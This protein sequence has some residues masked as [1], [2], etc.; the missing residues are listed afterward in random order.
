MKKI[1]LLLV[2]FVMSTVS[3]TIVA[4]DIDSRFDAVSNGAI[5]DVNSSCN[6]VLE[7]FYKFICS[8]RD[9]EEFRAERI[10]LNV[11]ELEGYVSKDNAEDV[12]EGS[13]EF[14]E[15]AWYLDIED[16]MPSYTS[17]SASWFDVSG[18]KACYARGEACEDG[19][20]E[21]EVI[22]IFE[23]IDGK[24]F[25][26]SYLELATDEDDSEDS[27]EEEDVDEEEEDETEEDEEDE[28][29]PVAQ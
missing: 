19:S 2:L 12:S 23:C 27:Y 1:G 14:Y 26:T 4:Q 15:E 17:F 9:D 10:N 22:Y 28:D 13:F 20:I 29:F 5:G 16:G 6:K 7:P 8:F 3:A 24:W 25:L 21:A 11:L 18:N